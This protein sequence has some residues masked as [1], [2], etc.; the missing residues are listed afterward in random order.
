MIRIRSRSLSLSL[1]FS[2][3]TLALAVTVF[4]SPGASAADPPI[5]VGDVVLVKWPE[6]KIL[7]GAEEVPAGKHFR[8]S[9]VLRVD[10]ARVKI[11]CDRRLGWVRADEVVPLEKAVEQVNV[12]LRD[13]PKDADAFHT[14]ANL[15]WTLPTSRVDLDQAIRLDPREPAYR[16]T[17][18]W[19]LEAAQ[20]VTN[21]AAEFDEAVRLA[22][23]DARV[24]DDR[25]L[26]RRHR[27]DI[28]GAIA[29]LQ[30]AAKLDPTDVDHPMNLGELLH[31]KGENE[32]AIAEFD[33]AIQI[34][35]NKGPLYDDRAV[36]RIDLGDYDK[37]I[38]DLDEA[39]RLDPENNFAF[40]NRGRARAGKHEYDKAIADFTK[41][42]NLAPE[43]AADAHIER[44]AAWRDKKDYD[45]A[46]ADFEKAVQLEPESGIALANRGFAHQMKGTYEQAKKDFDA[47]VSFDPRNAWVQN[48][49]AWFLA[50]CPDARFRDGKEAVKAAGI[51]CEDTGMK[52][53]DYLDTLAAA[54]AESG[55]FDAAVKTVGQAIALMPA[56]D[57]S[58]RQEYEARLA[59]YRK[60]TPYRE[61]ARR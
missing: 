54:Q 60:R 1:P 44:G 37:A 24:H 22:P 50:T 57:N 17:R 27:D 53:A 30:A 55:D 43:M 16:I 19:Y 29:D 18:G 35:P 61:K 26:F 56:S 39:V 41:A 33:R 49:R 59:L 20:D 21:A 32:K 7:V 47:A 45:K 42:I 15:L 5:K 28:D 31:I 25:A 6:T 40:Y 51:A 4:T 10:G 23:N 13:N 3:S 34:A 2:I 48:E 58:L 46:L 12:R 36:C 9:A 8:S 38:A 11:L 14:R 52:E